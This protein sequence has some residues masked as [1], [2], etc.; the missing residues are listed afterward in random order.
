HLGNGAHA[1][2]R[3]HPNY[4]W[5]QL[6]DDRLAASFIADGIH[7]PAAFLKTAFRAKGV[8]RTVL[9]TDAAAPAGCLP[10]RYT[11]AGQDVDLTADGRVT[12]AGQDGLAGSALRMDRA[13]ENA[14]RLGGVSLSQAVRMAT[15]N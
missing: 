9:V 15:C 11:L 8:D 14:I 12:L 6:A 5:D 1:F 4:L 3:R 13:V 10:G 7:L 2:L